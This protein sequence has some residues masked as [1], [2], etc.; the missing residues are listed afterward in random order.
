VTGSK[1]NAYWATDLM[2]RLF[3]VPTIS[4]GIVD[5]YAHGYSDLLDVAKKQPEKSGVDTDTLQYFAIDV[6]AYDIAA[7]GVGCS[8]RLPKQSVSVTTTPSSTIANAAPVSWSLS[9]FETQSTGT[10]LTVK[11]VPYS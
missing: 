5:H 10:W 4:E 6:W 8:G 3:H 7:P 11:L 2:H 9:R 1:L